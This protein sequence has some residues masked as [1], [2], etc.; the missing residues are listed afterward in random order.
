MTL[1]AS[2]SKP[3]KSN[4]RAATRAGPLVT[5]SARGLTER[6]GCGVEDY[7][8]PR[9]RKPKPSERVRV[10]VNVSNSIGVGY[11]PDPDQAE[12]W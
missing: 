9:R 8:A 11:G 2:I 6:H 5:P 3:S 4:T 7:L 12:V 10:A 1:S